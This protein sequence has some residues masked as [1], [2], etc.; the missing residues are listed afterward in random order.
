MNLRFSKHAKE[1]MIQRNITE[2]EVVSI[3]N[4]PDRII[5]ED[6]YL[7]YQRLSNSNDKPSHL[8]RV[9]INTKKDPSTVITVYKTS[10]IEKYL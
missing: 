2:E 7:I 4:N 1:R 9:F 6:E 3:I 8:F 5:E 10:K